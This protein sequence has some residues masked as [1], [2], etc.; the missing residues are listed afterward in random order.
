MLSRPA[1][2]AAAKGMSGT[3]KA[4]KDAAKSLAG[5]DEIERLDA[6]TGSSG[7]GSGASSITPNY[8]FDAK[9]PFLDSVLAA[10][11]AGAAIFVPSRATRPTEVIPAIAHSRSEA[12]N[13]LF[14]AFS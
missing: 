9:S 12:V 10:I 7:G 4:A 11:E 13:R 1:A 14:N 3:S 2:K 5:F 6:K 8:N